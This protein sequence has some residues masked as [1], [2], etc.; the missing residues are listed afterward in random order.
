[1][2]KTPK[3]FVFTN[4]SVVTPIETFAATVYVK[5][6]LIAEVKRGHVAPGKLKQI[7]LGGKHIF[8]GL[9]DA[10]V[11]FR[12]P[13]Q[14]EKEDWTTGSRAALAGGVTT[15]LDMPN[16]V[17]PVVDEASLERKREIVRREALVNYGFYAGATAGNVA[18]TNK[19]KNIAGVKLYMGS[20]TGDLLV[21]GTKDLDHYF[22]KTK[23]LLALHA[24][25]DDCIESW[26]EKHSGE[27]DPSVHSVIRSPECAYEAVK[28]ATH[29][30][31]KY[32]TRVHFCHVSTEKE[33]QTIAKF[34]NEK[35][36]VE[37]T[38]H[39]L[40]LTDKDYETYGN[41]IKVNPPVRSA[42]DQ[43]ALWEG[44]KTGLVDII[45]T[46]H[47][48]HLMEEKML[49]YDQAPSGIPG[50][51]TMLPLLLTAVNQGHLSIEK[52]VELTSVN[53]AKIFRIKGK[54]SVEE[55]FDADFAIVDLKKY[56]RL[57]HQYLWTKPDWSPFHGWW[58]TGWPVMTF[59]N[60]ELMYEWRET[61][62]KKIGKEVQF[63][64]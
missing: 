59:V 44:I 36:T 47:A 13:G 62:G 23:H 12:T 63:F 8:P 10:H 19:M 53:P 30:A 17:P 50:V 9:I 54:G 5:D 38:P 6:G 11:H 61:F 24:E 64:D 22:A 1:M 43:A 49:P 16:N 4:G 29:L 42:L 21:S 48:P 14:T 41:V 2:G 32:G 60:G 28:E 56:E 57:C 35:V 45:A 51:Q 20:S 27:N 58:L 39:H 52:V 31:K 25:S 18:A 46:D 40:F 55:G 26:K 33:L 34:K 7:D 15:V 3:E 37:V